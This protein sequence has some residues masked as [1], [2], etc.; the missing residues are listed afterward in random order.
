VFFAGDVTGDRPLLH[1]AADEGRIAGANAAAWPHLQHGHR[2]TPLAIAFTDPQ[3]AFVGARFGDL[4]PQCT[5][6]GEVDYE[7]QGRARVMGVDRGLVRIYGDRRTTRL[8]GA[9]LFGPRMEHLAH[10][11]AWAVQGQLTVNE[12]LQRPF[13]HPVLEE[14]L[15]TALRKLARALNVAN[16]C[17]PEDCADC[18]GA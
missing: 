17:P 16:R 12:A 3:I 5:A 1:E 4:D 6:I 7:N 18:P 15:R 2:R 13:Y 11:L 9:T 10:L 8:V 14:G